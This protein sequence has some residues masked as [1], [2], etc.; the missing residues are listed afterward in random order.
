MT[1]SIK[2]RGTLLCDRE[3]RR[4]NFEIKLENKEEQLNQLKWK[5]WRKRTKS[6][7]RERQAEKDDGI[8]LQDAH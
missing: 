3:I 7:A 6:G 4:A 5:H 1:A 2:E 8:V